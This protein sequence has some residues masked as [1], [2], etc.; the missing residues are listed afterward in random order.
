MPTSEKDKYKYFKL[1]FKLFLSHPV[2][3]MKMLEL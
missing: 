2:V 1:S 3:R